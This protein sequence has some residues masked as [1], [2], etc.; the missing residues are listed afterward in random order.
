MKSAYFPSIEKQNYYIGVLI[1][2]KMKFNCGKTRTKISG[3]P[4]PLNPTETRPIRTPLL[5][6]S[7][8]PLSPVAAP[9]PDAPSAQT[10]DSWSNCTKAGPATELSQVRHAGRGS[11]RVCCQRRT[12]G[13]PLCTW[14]LLFAKEI[15]DI[16]S[17]ISRDTKVLGALLKFSTKGH[18]YI[19][20]TD[21][22]LH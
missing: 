14:N 12:A 20:C 17:V 22:L 1:T 15:W 10:L 8:P 4:L 19:S 2:V 13:A 9:W 21:G 11:V 7:G 16:S 3:A 18:Q 6:T 5:S